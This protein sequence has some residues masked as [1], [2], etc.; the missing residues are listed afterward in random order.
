MTPLLLKGME[1]K[2]YI[3]D[4][5]NES[6]INFNV[7]D[8]IHESILKNKNVLVHCQMGISRSSTVVISY[9]MKYSGMNLKQAYHYVLNKKSN[10]FPNKGFL[11]QLNKFNKEIYPNEDKFIHPIM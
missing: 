6:T 8:S 9:L 2:I 11:A 4:D 5:L 10:I 7:L 3:V 1:H